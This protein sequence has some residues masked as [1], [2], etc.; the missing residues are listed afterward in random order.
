MFILHQQ[1][2]DWA[3]SDNRARGNWNLREGQCIAWVAIFRERVRNKSVISGI[4][5]R[6]MEEMINKQRARDLV[7]FILHRNTTLGDFDQDIDLDW[8]ISAGRD[9][10]D[11]HG[12]TSN[13]FKVE[14]ATGVF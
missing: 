10:A 11:V 14:H 12:C 3:T 6:G 4:V 5:H 1:S 13:T 2:P 8:R 9:F 7:Q